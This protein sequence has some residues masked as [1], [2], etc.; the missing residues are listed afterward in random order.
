MTLRKRYKPEL[1]EE[2]KE[3][4]RR[5]FIGWTYAT[6]SLYMLFFYLSQGN[7]SS[8]QILKFTFSFVSTADS[9]TT[10]FL[11]FLTENIQPVK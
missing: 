9:M 7:P 4:R 6:V 1:T 10:Y 3:K 8:T 5:F 2:E 11:Q